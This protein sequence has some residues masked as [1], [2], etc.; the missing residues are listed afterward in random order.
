MLIN[1]LEFVLFLLLSV[2]VFYALPQKMRW[3]VLLVASIVFYCSYKVTSLLYLALTTVITYLF[4]RWLGK[5]AGTKFDGVR[6]EDVASFKKSIG[7]KKRA[8]L[9]I[10]LMVDFSSLVVLKYSGFF[11]QLS[12]NFFKSNFTVPSFI[13]P[14][15]ISFYVFQTAGYLIDVYRG[16]YAPQKNVAKYALF[17]CFFPQMV[18]GPIN[19]YDAV[20]KQLY[21]GT[22]FDFKNIQK[23]F[24]CMVFGLLKKALIADPLWPIVTQIYSNYS[25][26][27][28]VISFFGAFLYCMQLYCDFSGGIDI[29][30]GAAWMFG[31][32]MQDNFMQPYFATSLA[33]F[34]RRWHI[35]LGEWMKDYL[36]FPLAFSKKASKIS[37]FARKHLTADIAKRII[38]CI[39]TLAVFIVVG[40][41]QGPGMQNIFY[42]IWNGFWMSIG[43][44]WTPFGSKLDDVIHYKKFK[45]LMRIK[46]V[47][48]TNLLVIIG[49]YFSNAPSL[50][51]ALGM[52][53]HTVTEFG[54]T[55]VNLE[56]FS[57]LGFSWSLA[58]RLMISLALLLV[59]S[60][61]KERKVDV[62]QWLCTRKWI[63]QYIILV[64]V[65]AVFVFGIY[66]NKNY[67]PI[68]FVYENV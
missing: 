12:N 54:A 30:Q 4:A 39:G 62:T 23:G 63:V 46:G 34:W 32:K 33:D 3:V 45:R 19:R 64:A 14:L 67:V 7:K 24:Y 10:A 40:M 37:K 51:S 2:A 18:Q 56:M 48:V 31:V 59:I 9:V 36:F 27:P 52:L 58:V 66:A 44:L 55:R 11:V 50:R 42:G 1:S 25:E 35:S 60:V 26:Y 15:G 6:R 43:L 8:V 28:G 68:S 17:V 57:A 47:V 5:L 38:P 53:S 13:L 65:F 21:G 16:K 20:E 41:W 61:A 22:S 49:R 29:V